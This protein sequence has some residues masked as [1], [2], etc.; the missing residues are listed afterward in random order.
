MPDDSERRSTAGRSF[1][2]ANAIPYAV[3]WK[4]YATVLKR[5]DPALA[6]A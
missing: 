4:T 6:C 3:V 5:F 1:I 2:A